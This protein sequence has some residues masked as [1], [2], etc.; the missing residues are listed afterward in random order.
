MSTKPR[1][2][3]T[4]DSGDFCLYVSISPDVYANKVPR[5]E[6]KN[7]QLKLA[8]A[9]RKFRDNV[10]DNVTHEVAQQLSA[11]FR[12]RI[13]EVLRAQGIETNL[14]VVQHFGSPRALHFACTTASSLLDALDYLSLEE[15]VYH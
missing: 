4:Q 12:D 10:P 5:S 3:G 7:L 2:N 15:R 11:Q 8:I 6:A 13:L 9:A 1:E 14:L